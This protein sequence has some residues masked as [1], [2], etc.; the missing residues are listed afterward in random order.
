MHT[1][2]THSDIKNTYEGVEEPMR[3]LQESHLALQAGL[4]IASVVQE[5]QY[6]ARPGDPSTCGRNVSRVEK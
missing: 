6:P 2:V 3:I 1:T 4:P 5:R